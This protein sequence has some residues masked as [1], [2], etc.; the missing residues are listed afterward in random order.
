MRRTER[1]LRSEFL[2][3]SDADR[4]AH[5]HRPARIRH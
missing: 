5:R 4:E 3:D 1:E 2:A